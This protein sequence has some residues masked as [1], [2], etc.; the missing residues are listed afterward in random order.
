MTTTQTV[1]DDYIQFSASGNAYN[2][3][4]IEQISKSTLGSDYTI[5]LKSVAN[6]YIEAYSVE[7][8]RNSDFS[9]LIGLITN[10]IVG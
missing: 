4:T 9:E 5:E 3:N 10:H 7:A 8:D 2:M 1:V 6:T